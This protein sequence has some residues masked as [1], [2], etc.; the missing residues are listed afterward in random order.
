MHGQISRAL[1]VAL[2]AGILLSVLQ[3]NAQASEVAP[4]S[5][6]SDQAQSPYLEP[7]GP[8]PLHAL[9]SLERSYVPAKSSWASNGV[10]LFS[11]DRSPAQ[12][13]VTDKAGKAILNKRAPASGQ[14]FLKFPKPTRLFTPYDVTVTAADGRSITLPVAVVDIGGDTAHRALFEP[15]STL[16]WSYEDDDAPTK[17]STISS[18]ITRSLR[19]ITEQTGLTFTPATDPDKADITFTWGNAEGHLAIAYGTGEINLSSKARQLRDSNSGFGRGGRAWILAHEI[20][21]ILGLQ[22][23]NESN[24]VM[25]PY[26]HTQS[27]FTAT[28]RALMKA[29]YK[30]QP[31]PKLPSNSSPTVD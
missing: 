26:M 3:G 13:T 4:E 30:M 1:T 25:H 17:S 20:L 5:T 29:L 8:V 24:S 14:V 16:T 21:H 9:F 10:R 18:D 12:V 31:C 15:C 7:T 22:H 6:N 28:D 11:G 2:S 19:A 23:T 27:K